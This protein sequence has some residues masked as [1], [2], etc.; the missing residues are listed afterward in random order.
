MPK[1][2]EAPAGQSKQLINGVNASL[3]DF[4]ALQENLNAPGARLLP[5]SPREDQ[6]EAP[7]NKGELLL[8]QRQTIRQRMLD[9]H[10]A[11]QKA[12]AGEGAAGDRGGRP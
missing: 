9:A 2:A 6:Q 4:D 8:Q 5:A 1:P 3:F 10:Y 12:A 11:K 7:S